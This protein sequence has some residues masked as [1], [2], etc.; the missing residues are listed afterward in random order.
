MNARVREYHAVF[1]AATG[2]ELRIGLGEYS[3]EASWFRFIQA[4]FTSDE[5]HFVACHLMRKIREGTRNIGCIRFSNLIERLD[6]FE[7][8]LGLAR[9]EQRNAKPQPT[10]KDRVIA[11]ARPT[12]VP[13]IPESTRDTSKHVSEYIAALRKAAQ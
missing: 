8:E 9:A 10:A 12:I 2:I 7:E 3:R 6:A 11:Q 4:G 13:M 1:C 5:V